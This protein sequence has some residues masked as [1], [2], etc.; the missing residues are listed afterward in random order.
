LLISTLHI[1]QVAAHGR[2]EP[3]ASALRQTTPILQSGEEGRAIY[4][5]LTIA[6][7]AILQDILFAGV[8]NPPVA[9]VIC[10]WPRTGRRAN[11]HIFLNTPTAA[12]RRDG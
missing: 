2:L 1:S 6:E 9:E 7:L 12:A 8:D 3:A 10:R 11:S 4:D 5:V